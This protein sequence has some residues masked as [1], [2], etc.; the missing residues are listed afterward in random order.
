MRCGRLESDVTQEL[1]LSALSNGLHSVNAFKEALVVDQIRLDAHIRS[2]RSHAGRIRLMG[3]LASTHATLGALDDALVI[4]RQ[5]HEWT[6]SKNG[7]KHK[8]S[9]F[10]G[11]NVVATLLNSKRYKEVQNFAFPWINIAMDTLGPGHAFTY[12]IID[13]YCASITSDKGSSADD[14]RDVRGMLEAAAQRCRL[15]LG[16]SHPTTYR[17]ANNLKAMDFHIARLDPVRAEGDT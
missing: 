2:N 10:S 1:G 9:I 8:D 16:E 3:A 14:I 17:L 12:D 5:V 6:V 13:T 7:E 4:H 11:L 15:V